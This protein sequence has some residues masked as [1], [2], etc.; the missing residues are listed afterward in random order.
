MLSEGGIKS[1]RGRQTSVSSGSRQ[2]DKGNIKT[3]RG[4]QLL[5]KYAT[6]SSGINLPR[7][8]PNTYLARTRD[9]THDTLYMA[10]GH[11]GLRKSEWSNVQCMPHPGMCLVESCPPCVAI[12]LRRCGHNFAP[13]HSIIY[14]QN[15]LY[16]PVIKGPLHRGSLQILS[17][18]YL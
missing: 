4:P 13:P 10:V 9:V 1:S 6:Y 7:T 18:L 16:D 17:V 11:I 5:G 12:L 3:T 15:A 14:H 2:Q 8:L